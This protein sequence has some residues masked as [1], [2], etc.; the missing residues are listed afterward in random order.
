[1]TYLWSVNRDVY[2]REGFLWDD[3]CADTTARHTSELE[4]ETNKPS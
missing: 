1:M 2:S 4:V 3:V